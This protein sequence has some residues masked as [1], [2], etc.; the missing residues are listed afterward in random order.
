MAP[1]DA[2]SSPVRPH[3][4]Q[5]LQ[6]TTDTDKGTTTTVRA[7]ACCAINTNTIQV[8]TFI[9]D[10]IVIVMTFILMITPAAA[11]SIDPAVGST[12]FSQWMYTC[13]SR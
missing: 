2:I 6:L 3:A 13:P 12:W 9:L 11:C 10:V 1:A 5:P 8:I 7:C 4:E